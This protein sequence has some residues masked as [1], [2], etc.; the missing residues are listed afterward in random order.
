MYWVSRNVA[1][2]SAKNV[3]VMPVLAAVKRGFLKK[4]TSSIGW[5]VVR[6]HQMNV[7]SSTIASPNATRIGGSVQ[8]SVGASM[9]P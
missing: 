4:R 7:P 1:P 9:M 8:P 6:C 5:S 3:I 2:N